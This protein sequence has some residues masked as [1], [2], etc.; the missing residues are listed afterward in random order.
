MINFTKSKQLSLN[1]CLT[2]LLHVRVLSH[3]VTNMG[4]NLLYLWFWRVLECCL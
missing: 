4:R 1:A 2:S 3:W